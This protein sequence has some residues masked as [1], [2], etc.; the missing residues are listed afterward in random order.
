MSGYLQLAAVAAPMPLR[1]FPWGTHTKKNLRKNKDNDNPIKLSTFALNAVSE[2]VHSITNTT[3]TKSKGGFASVKTIIPTASNGTPDASKP[4]RKARVIAPRPDRYAEE[5]REMEMDAYCHHEIHGNDVAIYERAESK[6]SP[7]KMTML[8]D[9]FGFELFQLIVS[10]YDYD[11]NPETTSPTVSKEIVDRFLGSKKQRLILMLKISQRI[12]SMHAHGLVHSDLKPENIMVN[13]QG[14]VQIID[15]GNSQEDGETA[16]QFGTPAYSAPEIM[17]RRYPTYSK[18]ADLY[19][20]AKLL[21]LTLGKDSGYFISQCPSSE[22]LST[23]YFNQR[24]TR[25]LPTNISPKITQLVQKLLAREP[26]D[27]GTIQ[28]VIEI[29]AAEIKACPSA[30]PATGA[31]ATVSPAEEMKTSPDAEHKSIDSIAI[32]RFAPRLS[33]LYQHVVA[34][35][36]QR[37]KHIKNRVHSE[38]LRQLAFDI[39][40]ISQGKYD[41]KLNESLMDSLEDRFSDIQNDIIS[42]LTHLNHQ[43]RQEATRL[44]AKTFSGKNTRLALERLSN[45]IQKITEG[46]NPDFSDLLR[47]AKREYEEISQQHSHANPFKKCF[48]SCAQTDTAKNCTAFLAASAAASSNKYTPPARV[49]ANTASSATIN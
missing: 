34:M 1:A 13:T 20:L 31:G 3:L 21:I 26:T 39:L 36:L 37:H 35:K 4:Q 16:H 14:D 41:I 47:R 9:D 6:H 42:E 19:G 49:R 12:A 18:A 28:D 27:R 23:Y 29:L 24:D 7:A 38:S 2:Q 33:Q 43:I 45:S 10:K 30:A 8:M 46:R 44:K 22:H 32:A 5:R 11:K 48:S 17:F 15:N 25:Q 40:N